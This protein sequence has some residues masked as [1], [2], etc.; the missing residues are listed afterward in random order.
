MKNKKGF[1]LIELLAIIVILAIIAVITV[2]IILNII[3]NARRGAVQNS[4]LGYKDA[5]H[6]Y[7]VSRLSIDSNFMMADHIYEIID[8]GYL[9][10]TDSNDSSNDVL[11]EILLDGKVPN[12]GYVEI[13]RNIV[14][15]ACIAFDDYAV[16]ISDGS[17]SDV[18]KGECN[19]VDGVNGQLAINTE[20]LYPYVTEGNNKEQSLVVP[21]NGYYKLEVWGASGGTNSINNGAITSRGGYGGYSTGTIYL[22]KGKIIYINVGGKG[23]T[24]AGTN[25]S[26]VNG[27][28]NGGAACT[29]DEW[30][31]VCNTSGGATHIALKSGQLY[32]LKDYKGEY[33]STAGVHKS[34]DILIVAGGGGAGGIEVNTQNGNRY[35]SG[36]SGGGYKGASGSKSSGISDPSA[37][38]GTQTYTNGSKF[39]Q[40]NNGTG[41]YG[42]SGAGFYSGSG[43]AGGGGGSGYIGNSSLTNKIM[44]CYD[45][46]ESEG[47]E[48]KTVSTTN[49]NNPLRDGINCS[50][51]YANSPVSKCAKGEDGYAKITYIGKTLE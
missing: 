30:A 25:G 23:S 3:E 27:G 5:I 48:T 17:V 34:T 19:G 4:A 2:P 7:Y 20:F 37:P 39:G 46:E 40:A 11:Y 16:L 49:T 43:G 35:T 47:T 9:S 21:T 50:D 42:V 1:T 32:E 6:K 28:Y 18:L 8:N 33:D 36:G 10:Y 22:K 13:Q 44:Y 51:G 12:G 14:K 41:W 24:N 15:N 29:K 26:V 38:G 31:M 45:C